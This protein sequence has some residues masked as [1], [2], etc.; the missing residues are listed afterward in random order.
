VKLGGVSLGSDLA[1]LLTILKSSA[2]S[3]Q[4]RAL[5]APF[6]APNPPSKYGLRSDRTVS[7]AEEDR[8][9][10]HPF[11]GEKHELGPALLADRCGYRSYVN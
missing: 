2:A 8:F 9:R 6:W 7:M 5:E 1:K 11:S 10:M 4:F 3:G